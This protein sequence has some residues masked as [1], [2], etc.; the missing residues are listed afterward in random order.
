MVP[1]A[2]AVP[3]RTP[4]SVPGGSISRPPCPHPHP[5]GWRA[6]SVQE[7]RRHWG[8]VCTLGPAAPASPCGRREQL[9]HNRTRV[10]AARERD[11]VSLALSQPMRSSLPLVPT[12]SKTP[13]VSSWPW[14]TAGCSRRH[15]CFR[16]GWRLLGGSAVEGAGLTSLLSGNP[17]PP[18]PPEPGG[19]SF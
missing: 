5:L 10:Q 18:P 15:P 3:G 9:L 16:W 2:R 12:I 19:E 4:R 14:C 13:S 11:R 17:R 7:E 6:H 8:F 1:A